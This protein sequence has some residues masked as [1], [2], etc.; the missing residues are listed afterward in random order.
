MERLLR[1][2]IRERKI[3]W[4]LDSGL[5]VYLGLSDA[6][7]FPHKGVINFAGNRV[8]AGNEFVSIAN[9]LATIGL[10]EDVDTWV[11]KENVKQ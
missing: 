4:S 7:G 11:A 10:R 1:R 9:G 2:L 5:P 6:T 3:D 8:D